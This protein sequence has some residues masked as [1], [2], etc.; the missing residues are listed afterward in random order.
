VRNAYEYGDLFRDGFSIVLVCILGSNV[1]EFMGVLSGMTSVLLH[2]CV[3]LVKLG[4][5]HSGRSRCL[6]TLD[7]HGVAATPI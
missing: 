7:V 4:S 3:A 1:F 2:Q 6:T 5:G